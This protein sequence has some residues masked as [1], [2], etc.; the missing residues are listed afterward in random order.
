MPKETVGWLVQNHLAHKLIGVS[1]HV[2][3]DVANT[4][5]H[6]V[7]V[8][9]VGGRSLQGRGLAEAYCRLAGL[10]QRW[11]WYSEGRSA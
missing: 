10:A 11:E 8:P 9:G 6:H 5:S 2:F 3:W 7:K 1:V 4:P